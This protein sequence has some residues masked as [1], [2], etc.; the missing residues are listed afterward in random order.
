MSLVKIEKP[1]SLREFLGREIAVTGWFE[2]TQGRI[3]QFADA[4]E[5]RQWI[6]VDRERTRTD[7]PYGTTIA[8]GFLTLSLLS[9]FIH[10]AIELGGVGMAINYGLDRVRF[11]APVR[12]A[13]RIRARISLE[14]TREVVDAVEATYLVTIE[15]EG[16]EKPCCIA[17]WLVR[18]YRA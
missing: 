12:A 1:E 4:T 13:T 11:P 7:S 8:H 14:S 5:D 17:E 3:D 10:E 18:Y 15:G 16:S 9:H 6:H 2:I